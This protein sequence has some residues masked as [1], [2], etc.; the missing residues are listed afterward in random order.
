M[1]PARPDAHGNRIMTSIDRI[2]GLS[3]L[4]PA[5][6]ASTDAR[7]AAIETMGEIGHRVLAWV[8][9]A[10]RGNVNG[11]QACSKTAG[12]GSGFAPDMGELARRGDVYGL[13][14]LT[15]DLSARF[16]A[17]PRRDGAYR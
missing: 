5:G 14:D 12:N 11:A 13:G 15:R 10:S 17:Q 7:G 1:P 4:S 2:S 6:N 16:G 9:A 8:D 3:P